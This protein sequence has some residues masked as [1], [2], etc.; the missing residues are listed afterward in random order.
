[1]DEL[2]VWQ[3]YLTIG[4]YFVVV[5]A[6]GIWSTCRPNKGSTVGY[7]LAGRDMHWIPIGA[8]IYASNVG[9]QLFIA[10]TGTAAASGFA[11]AIYEWHAI[12]ILIALGWIF[13]PVYVACGA[14]TMPEYL[15]KRF[16]GQRIRVVTSITNIASFVLGN[17]SAEIYCGAMFME[18]LL[19]WNIYLCVCIIIVVTAIYTITGGLVSVIYTD[20]LQTV[21]LLGGAVYLAVVA[22]TTVGGWDGLISRYPLAAANNTLANQ[23]FYQCGMPR[24]DAFHI[25]RDPTSGDIPWPGAA[26]GLTLLGLYVWCQEQ[27]IVQRC[28]SGRSLSHAK[29]GAL[30]AAFLKL[31][32]FIL[33]IIPG[34]ISR[35]LYP[36]EVACSDPDT[37]WE[38]CQNRAGCSSLAYPLLV[39]RLLPP[40]IRG[41][42]L[43]ALLAAMMSSLTS[44]FNSA[45]AI[46]TLDLWTRIRHR[47][48]ETELMVVGR[49]TVVLLLIISILW[50]PILQV[51]Q[52]G[53]LWFYVQAVKAYLTV[54]FCMVFL[55]GFFWKRLS[56]K[57]AFWGLIAGLVIGVIRLVLDFSMPAPL[58]GSGE[59]DRR[60]AFVAKVDFLHF[61]MIAA[62]LCSLFMVAIS[63]FTKP[64]TQ[65][66]LNR[67]TFWTRHAEDEPELSE[68]ENDEGCEGDNSKPKKATSG[69]KVG[70]LLLAAP[71][72]QGSV[73]IKQFMM[74]WLCG[75]SNKPKKV[76]TAE[77]KAVIR[78]KMTS[79]KQNVTSGRILNVVAGLVSGLTFTLLIYFR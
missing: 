11:V 5:L 41:L 61:A 73:R 68:N 24:E 62:L 23:S 60:F 58:C 66:Q 33:F 50:L 26:I 39:M 14:Y 9:S 42:M 21:I 4:L 22:L 70:D 6:V 79:I 54:P 51:S 47:A 2:L 67:V 43:A 63:F 37:C 31:F 35:I 59:P 19:G 13:V 29:A 46:V 56:E 8:S 40:G 74:N 28:L 15:R 1:M 45:S 48:R 77:E 20:T 72:E 78:R 12:F 27:I 52:G 25:W 10:L 49:M 32:S 57:A 75:F 36:D 38:I 44:I 3:D 55:I 7:F 18:I 76:V 69:D 64:R 17:I 16:G 30:F 71:A 34:M 65:S 53:L